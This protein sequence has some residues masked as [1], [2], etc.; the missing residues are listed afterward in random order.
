MATYDVAGR[1]AIV[2][3]AGA[4]I[5]REVALLLARNGAHV[6]AQDINADA[7][8][9]VVSE[10]E[11]AGGRAAAVVGD[12]GDEAII[13]EYIR[14]AQALGPFGIAIN[15]AGISGGLAP[16]GQYT[17]A[18]WDRTVALNIT[19]VFRGLRA[20]VN[21][22]AETGGAIVNMASMLGVIGSAGS[23]AY[24]ATKHAVVGLTK[25]TAIEY[26]A[27]GIRVNAVAPGYVDTALIG[28]IQNEARDFLAQQHPIG[29]LARAEEIAQM[30]VFLASDAASFVT[31]STHVIDGGFTAR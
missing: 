18:D 5:G 24:A 8:A 7:A 19:T 12:A 13:G 25:T 14:A 29:R 28:G 16:T 22:M 26:A 20:Q 23:P 30:V 17:D 27:A 6:V 21:A 31:G 10:I 11:A 4:G 2:T 15:N 9:A 1:S 3:G